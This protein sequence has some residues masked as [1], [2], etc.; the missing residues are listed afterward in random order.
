[1]ILPP[2]I[3]ISIL[4]LTTVYGFLVNLFALWLGT[5]LLAFEK[6]GFMPAFVTAALY[7]L[8]YA[9]MF[10]VSYLIG[11]FSDLLSMMLIY[12]SVLFSAILLMPLIKFFYKVNWRKAMTLWLLVLGF[13]TVI[14]VLLSLL[15]ALVTTAARVLFP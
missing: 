8:A 15:L 13:N 11:A 5:K 9:V 1:M 14:S 7:T 2:F 10:S 6:K 4:A 12:A 3:G